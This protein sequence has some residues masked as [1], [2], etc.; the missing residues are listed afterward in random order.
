MHLTLFVLLT[1][2]RGSF[3]CAS[4]TQTLLPGIK[5]LL[6]KSLA[7]SL[8]GAGEP[9]S[10]GGIPFHAAHVLINQKAICALQNHHLQMDETLNSC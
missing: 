6:G 10:T 3:G 9:F 5:L 2:C 1:V 8:C 4:Q 7:V